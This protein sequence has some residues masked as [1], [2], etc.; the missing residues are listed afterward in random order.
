[1]V[2]EHANGDEIAA[3]DQL[4]AAWV[5]LGQKIHGDIFPHALRLAA[6]DLTTTIT[7]TEFV[8]C[9][10]LRRQQRHDDHLRQNRRLVRCVSR[11]KLQR[12]RARKHGARLIPADERHH[13]MA[14]H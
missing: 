3:D 10:R 8:C 11:S 13:T 5:T 1:V 6:D 7:M 12:H 9:L 4:V 14:Q 2:L